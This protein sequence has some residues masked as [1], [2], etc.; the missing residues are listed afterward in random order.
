MIAEMNNILNYINN[1]SNNINNTNA[2]QATNE[3]LKNYKSWKKVIGHLIQGNDGEREYGNVLIIFS[4]AIS[5]LQTISEN[6]I[7][8]LKDE[9]IDYEL[10][11][12]YMFNIKLSVY[13]NLGYNWQKLG[14]KYINY[15]ID[16]FKKY[17]FYQLT[18]SNHTRYSNISCFAFRSTSKFLYQSLI[19]ETL[20]L[21]SPITFND[22][23]DCPI[24]ELMNNE[25]ET[26]QLIRQAY[27]SGVRIACFVKNEKLPYSNNEN[28]LPITNHKKN[29]RD[30][31]E[32]LNELMWSHYA[33]SH[34][35]ICIKYNLPSSL[36]S[37]SGE[38]DFVT[39]FK[40]VEYSSSLKHYSKQSSIQ[41]N[42]AFF[43]K[44]K[45]WK[46]ENELRF[47]YYNP[48]NRDLHISIPIQ[49]SIEAIYFG[50][51]CSEKDKETIKNILRN[52]K[53]FYRKTKLID[54][55]LQDIIEER[56]IKFYQ[57]EMNKKVFGEIKAVRI[58]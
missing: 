28:D 53:C 29:T 35:G 8:I 49:N 23:F 50:V 40:D 55:K 52:K 32:Y 9:I 14:I 7:I 51:K 19:N 38:N 16:A 39:Y 56:E 45:S 36:T 43:V 27:L 57:M 25:D 5:E 24:I 34:M 11:V 22:L 6:N 17:I 10:R 1:Y 18:L 37:S 41:I 21:S 54:N 12:K 20:N 30:K 4:A 26:S 42:E 46:Y 31:K 58:S 48:N 47:L 13:F 15:A 2:I 33:D 44:G 3:F